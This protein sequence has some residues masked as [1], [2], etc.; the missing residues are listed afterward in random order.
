[1][2][3]DPTFTNSISSFDNGG[4]AGWGPKGITTKNPYCGAASA[5][6]LGSCWPNGGSLDR[7]LN[8]ANGNALKPNT[9]YRLRAMINS[10]ASTG[11]FQFEIAGYDGGTSKLFQ[12]PNTSGWVQFDETF[13][14]GATVTEHGI[15]FNSC[16]TPPAVTDTCFIDNYE[17]YEVQSG[18]G[19]NNQFQNKQSIY[20]QGDNIVS[21]FQLN[22]Q[23]VVTFTIV[24]LQGKVLVKSVETLPAGKNKQLFKNNFS[25]GIYLVKCTSNEFTA[26]NKIIIR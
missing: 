19:L 11:S 15:Y 6:I 8:T 22:Q 26:T 14:T 1:M 12:I 10:Q 9:T 4:Y 3:A 21:E 5:Y 24:D 18:T 17:L 20:V 23:S 2:I 16:T 13:T 7:G 25:A